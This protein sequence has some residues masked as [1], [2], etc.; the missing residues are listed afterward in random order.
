MLSASTKHTNP[1]S[2]GCH[3]SCFELFHPVDGSLQCLAKHM[4]HVTQLESR[5]ISQSRC[6]GNTPCALGEA[7]NKTSLV[8][9]Q[10]GEASNSA[11]TTGVRN[12]HICPA[13]LAGLMPPPLLQPPWG[14][15]SE[16]QGPT[17]TK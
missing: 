2:T 6:G 13:V 3:P 8:Q 11:T 15:D 4:V 14:S 17:P 16:L 9:E 5:I 7:D 1:F 12:L 10:L